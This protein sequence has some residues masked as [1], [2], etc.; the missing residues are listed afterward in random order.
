MNIKKMTPEQV[1]DWEDKLR[2]EIR[3]KRALLQN[4]EIIKK[5]DKK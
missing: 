2:A 3:A 4:K 1:K 5:T